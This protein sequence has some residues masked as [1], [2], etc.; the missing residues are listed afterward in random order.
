SYTITDSYQTATPYLT[1]TPTGD[2]GLG[3]QSPTARL[4]VA[5]GQGGNQIE[6][7][8]G[9]GRVLF[10]QATNEH[11]LILYGGASGA[12]IPYCI[13]HEG[14]NMTIGGTAD[15]GYD[16]DVQGMGNFTSGVNISNGQNLTWGGTYS[17]GRPT[18]AGDSGSGLG[19]Y[20]SG[21][22]YVGKATMV[23]HK[24]DKV[25]IGMSNLTGANAKFSVSGSTDLFGVLNCS[26]TASFGGEILVG[27]PTGVSPYAAVN[28]NYLDQKLN[29]LP[30]IINNTTVA[31]LSNSTLN[32]NYPSVAIGSQIVC[33]AVGTGVIYVKINSNTW[34]QMYLNSI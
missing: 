32:A 15:N 26:S 19:F 29:G 28:I 31:A 23:V 30:K 2:V 22:T 8:R 9:S 20:P 10:G 13:W 33:G 16:L 4:S 3:S 21:A 25:A 24:L 1:I 34:R 12:E 14:G 6:M 18:I 27:D 5:N 17:S 7:T 11:K